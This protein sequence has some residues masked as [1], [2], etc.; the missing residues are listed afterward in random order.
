MTSAAPLGILLYHLGRM[1]RLLCE[2]QYAAQEFNQTLC[3]AAHQEWRLYY[4]YGKDVCTYGTVQSHCHRGLCL[5]SGVRA[6][7]PVVGIYS[8][9]LD[10]LVSAK[11][12]GD[13]DL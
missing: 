7:W 9:K 1:G 10:V 12:C 6:G 13:Q 4:L 5:R 11:R 2:E 3:G 8:E